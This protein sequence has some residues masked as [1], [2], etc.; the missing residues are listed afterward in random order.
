MGLFFLFLFFVFV[1]VVVVV[2][3]SILCCKRSK[4]SEKIYTE[5]KGAP[6]KAKVKRF[7]EQKGMSLSPAQQLKKY[8]PRHASCF[9][10]EGFAHRTDP[11]VQVLPFAQAVLRTHCD[12]SMSPRGATAGP[13]CTRCPTSCPCTV[14]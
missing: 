4:L 13:A 3:F 2:F 1:V 14:T 12:L 10:A 6:L 5:G 11:R 7:L 8:V 9:M